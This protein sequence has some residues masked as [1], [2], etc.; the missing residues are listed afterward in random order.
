[1]TKP[2]RVV[3]AVTKPL[4]DRL[5]V[6]PEDSVA[7]IGVDDDAFTAQLAER[8]IRRA[9]TRATRECNLVFYAADSVEALD[10]LERLRTRITPNGAIWVVSRKGKGAPLK[11]TDVIA[12]AK[13]AGLVDT[14]VVAFSP[15][16]TSLKL[17]IPLA[18][19]RRLR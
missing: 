15:T 16:H 12:A 2:Q 18:D 19:R 8:L 11:D 4:L 13:R 14:K 17:V 9:S 7:V 1:M 10:R 5:G 3:A 6:R